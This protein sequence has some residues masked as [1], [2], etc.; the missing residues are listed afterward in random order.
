M[1]ENHYVYIL[2]CRGGVLYTGYTVDLE[3][4]LAQHMSGKGSRFTRSHLPVM[5][6]HKES[7]RTKRDAMRREIAIKRL[8]RKRKLLLAGLHNC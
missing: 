4:R 6:V 3:R 2:R 7:Y 1:R 8:S 5:I